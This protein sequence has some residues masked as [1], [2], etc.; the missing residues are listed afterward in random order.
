MQRRKGAEGAADA[1]GA[2]RGEEARPLI[3]CLGVEGEED[4]CTQGTA[5][6]AAAAAAQVNAGYT[7]AARLRLGGVLA[8]AGRRELPLVG[9]AIA[10]VEVGD[11]GEGRGVA[12]DAVFDDTQAR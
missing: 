10:R 5:A 2:Y 3:G 4:G 8:R 7:E 1:R 6:A 9:R 12:L 11:R